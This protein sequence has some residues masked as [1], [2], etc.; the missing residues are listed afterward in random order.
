MSDEIFEKF[1]VDTELLNFA[2]DE[3]YVLEDKRYAGIGRM[4]AKMR[5]DE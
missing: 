3:L 5:E 1:G 4:L 2:V